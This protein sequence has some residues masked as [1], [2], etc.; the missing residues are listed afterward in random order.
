MLFSRFAMNSFR[1][2]TKMTDFETENNQ[3][4]EPAYNYKLISKV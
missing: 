3:V 2:A 4:K 1:R